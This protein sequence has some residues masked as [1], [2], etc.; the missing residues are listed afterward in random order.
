MFWQLVELLF[1]FISLVHPN[2][3]KLNNSQLDANNSRVDISGRLK[4]LPIRK[5]M[6][7]SHNDNCK[8][9]NEMYNMY[10]A[11]IISDIHCTFKIVKT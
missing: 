11:K 6:G 5:E 10:G 4:H 9:V 1:R 2:E 8:C 7:V 3:K